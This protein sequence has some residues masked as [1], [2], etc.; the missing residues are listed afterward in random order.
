MDFKYMVSVIVPIYNAQEQIKTTIKSLISQTID[1]DMMEIILIDDGSTDKSLELCRECEEEYFYYHI[2]VITQVNGGPSKARNTGMSRAN[3]KYIMFLDS[4]DTLEVNTIKNVSDFFEKNAEQIDV[5]TYPEITVINGIKQKKHF[6]YSYL[7]KT[8]IYDLE[9]YQFAIQTRLGISIKNKKN[10]LVLFD[11]EMDYHEDQKFIVELLKDKMKIGFCAEACYYYNRIESGIMGTKTNSLYLFEVTMKFYEELFSRYEIVPKY[12]Q[13]MLLHDMSWKLRCNVL[14]PHHYKGENKDKALQRMKNLLLYI[15]DSIILDHPG[16]DFYHRFYFLKFKDSKLTLVSS[17]EGTKLIYKKQIVHTCTRFE[18]VINS[19]KCIEGKIK[20]EGLVKSPIF[21]FYG[22]PLV[23]ANI[24][25]GKSVRKKLLELNVSAESYYRCKTKTNTFY[26]FLFE[27]AIEGIDEIFFTVEIDSFEYAVTYFF[28]KSCAI[29]TEQNIFLTKS[30][31]IK[32]D[33]STFLIDKLDLG[34]YDYLISDIFEKK[35]SY[36]Y[37]RELALRV[38]ADYEKKIWLYFDCIGVRRDNGFIQFMHDVKMQDGIERYYVCVN[39]REDYGNI[40]EKISER[41]IKHGSIKHKSLFLVAEKIITAYIE[42]KN[43]NPFNEYEFQ[44]VKC[45]VNQE[46]I[47][48][49]HGIL[50]AHLPWKYSPGRIDCDKIVVSS[51]FELK[52]FVN[53]YGYRKECLIPAGMPRFEEINQN[54]EAE[55]RI[56]FAPSWRNYLIGEENGIEWE[57][58]GEKLLKSN[59]YKGIYEFLN[60]PQLDKLLKQYNV[61]LE[62]KLHPIFKPYSEYFIS[63]SEKICFA[64]EL[65]KDEVYS[66][67]ITD[68]SSYVFNFAYLKRAILYFIS[69]DLEFRSGMNQYWELDLPFEEAFGEYLISADEAVQGL[70]KILEN[71][72]QPEL[73]YK[74]RMEDF[75]LE[76]KDCTQKVYSYIKQ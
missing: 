72:L 2:E 40:A 58:A 42:T 1:K 65:T 22:E 64:D 29:S 26:Q 68:F 9:E 15:D 13:A 38:S 45:L 33:K 76:I 16:I 69:D 36:E 18:M 8:G 23:Y 30:H 20:F 66:V 5:V 25:R 48:L 28:M 63:G 10:E 14:F 39:Q 61:Q 31:S 21:D 17:N 60:S 55:R 41:I 43:Y 56:L 62:L 57:L 50:H 7:N 37:L 47:Y 67:F 52:N 51:K 44:Q 75:F 53:I 4:D 12:F 73:I 24:K 49:Q 70:E 27:E 35:H 71:D 32:Y 34:K 6:R 46:V 19:I 59:Y 74:K 11:E 3:G 54:I